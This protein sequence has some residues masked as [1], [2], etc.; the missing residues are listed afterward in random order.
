MIKEEGWTPQEISGRSRI[1]FPDDKS[2]WICH[3]TIYQ[4]A[5][6]KD[7]THRRI[8]EYLPRGRKTRRKQHGRRVHTSRINRRMSI[9]AR[10]TLVNDRSGFGH[11]EGDSIEGLRS[12]GD[13]IHTEVERVTRFTMARKVASITS[14]TASDAQ[15][16]MF[17]VLPAHAR[18]STTLDN[19][20]ENHLHHRLID[21]LGMDT[22]FAHP[23]SSFERGTS[24]H[25]NGQLRRY[26]PKGTDLSAV[27]DEDLAWVVDKINHRPLKCL[28]WHTPSEAF[29]YLATHPGAHTLPWASPVRGAAAPIN[30]TPDPT[31]ALPP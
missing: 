11:W 14:Q 23:Y 31:V 27:T 8:W 28:D 19:G 9:S 17:A 4:W 29:H 20:R 25:F 18:L 22:Y 30:S 5:Y 6:R 26:F 1:D 16:G 12:I 2:M 21:E 3:E 24:E 7:Q 13:G 10:P 15:L